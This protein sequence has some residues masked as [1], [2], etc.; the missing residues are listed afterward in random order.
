MSLSKLKENQLMDFLKNVDEVVG[1]FPDI[2]NNYF[3]ENGLK[4]EYRKN[5]YNELVA[6]D[7]N[8]KNKLILINE[9]KEGIE[10]ETE[11]ERIKDFYLIVGKELE[12]LLKECTDFSILFYALITD[13]LL[14]KV[15]MNE[16]VL[17][18]DAQNLLRKYYMFVEK[19]K[20]F[21]DK[22]TIFINRYYG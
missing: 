5:K 15:G 21:K 1:S 11:D 8:L 16:D 9:T 17:L 10:E 18:Q 14:C 4:K 12:E 20:P 22:I 2:M 19:I 3:D 6:L 7:N 13:V